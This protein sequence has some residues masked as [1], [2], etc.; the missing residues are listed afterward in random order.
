MEGGRRGKVN[1]MSWDIDTTSDGK[2]M[3]RTVYG[4]HGLSYGAN[5]QT[6][7]DIFGAFDKYKVK[8]YA[9]GYVPAKAVKRI[10]SFL[11][12]RYEVETKKA[13]EASGSHYI[14]GDL[15][16]WLPESKERDNLQITQRMI[17]LLSYA[18]RSKK[19]ILI[20]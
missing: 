12:S 13:L 8:F 19:G 7:I 15:E 2:T 9:Q 5:T 20:G 17:N 16:T 1:E 6:P 11:S 18:Y 4:I 10:L 14:G 3:D